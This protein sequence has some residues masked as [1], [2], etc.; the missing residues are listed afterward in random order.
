MNI[1]HQIISVET[2]NYS[3]IKLLGLLNDYITNNIMG[4]QTIL[5][6]EILLIYMNIQSSDIIHQSHR[7][8]SFRNLENSNQI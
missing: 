3:S 5:Q 7:D 8:T 2:V 6:R 4:N 1:Q